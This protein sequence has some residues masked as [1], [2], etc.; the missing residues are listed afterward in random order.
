M[1]EGDTARAFL[2]WIRKELCMKEILNIALLDEDT[3][4]ALF[5]GDTE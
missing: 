5:E 2:T 1:F 4:R 3:D